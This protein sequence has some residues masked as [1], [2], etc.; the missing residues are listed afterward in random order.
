MLNDDIN[1][2]VLPPIDITANRD[3]TYQIIFFAA[4]FLLV[5]LRK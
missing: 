4:L 1:T 2:Y 3:Y 5:G